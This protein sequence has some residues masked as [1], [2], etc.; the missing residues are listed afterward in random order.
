MTTAAPVGNPAAEEGAD[1]RDA[2][3]QRDV[4][5]LRADLERIAGRYTTNRWDAEDLVQETL[6][7]A[8]VG[9]DSFQPGTNLRAW[10][11]RIM[12]NTWISAHRKAE[13]RP[14]ETLTDSFTDAQLVIDGYRHGGLPSAE[15][16]AL[17]RFPNETLADAVRAL[18]GH[19]QEAI[20]YADVQQL[21]HRTIA[22][23]QNVPVGTVMSRL[24]RARRQLRTVLEAG[25]SAESGHHPACS[26]GQFC[27]GRAYPA[28][29]SPTL[30]PGL[31]SCC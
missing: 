9:F 4:V 3:F 15:A 17:E 25:R 13:R 20:Y 31:M 11:S 7:K 14:Q 18:P 6:T 24:H 1:A 26:E 28:G 16:H 8:W 30:M 10:L 19:L 5:G 21:P 12:V 27:T 29:L 22:D 2:R 23:L